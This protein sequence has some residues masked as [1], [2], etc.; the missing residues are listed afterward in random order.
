MPLSLAYTKADDDKWPDTN[1]M[2]TACT[3][4]MMYKYTVTYCH[5]RESTWDSPQLKLKLRKHQ[6]C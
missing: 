1:H 5:A 2:H 3:T 4:S 6:R